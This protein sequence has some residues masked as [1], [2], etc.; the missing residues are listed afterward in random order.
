M[1]VDVLRVQGD[2]HII[3]NASTTTNGASGGGNITLDVGGNGVNTGTVVITGNLDVRG[4]TTQ[5]ESINATIKDNTLILNSGEPNNTTPGGVTNGTSGIM[6]SR[7]RA[8]ADT[9]SIG[10]FLEWNDNAQWAGTG[11]LSSVRGVWEFR[12]GPTGSG[13]KYSAIKV[14][15]IRIDEASASTAGS[16][17]GLGARLNI[18][19]SDN[20]TSVI[21]VSG[22]INYESRVTDKDDIPNK[23]YVDNTL[24][25][26]INTAQSLID[27]HSY[28]KIL[29]NYLDGVTSEVIAVLDG[30]PTQRL[31]ITTGTVVMRLT[32]AVAQFSEIQFV[33]N[34]IQPTGTNTDLKLATNGSGRIILEAPLVFNSLVTPTSP[35][36]GQTNL[37]AS[38][39][40]G[41]GTGMYFQTTDSLSV[42]TSDEFVSRKKALVFSIIFG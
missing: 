35:P 16:G 7:G 36:I 25:S 24:A 39:A 34:Q 13:A 23:A 20:P 11:V 5:I 10:A 4:T 1:T 41:G 12:E 27:G 28:L 37:Y 32:A 8:G 3:T 38:T 18:L 2:Y 40:G 17:Q 22:T 9:P 29:D 31:N 21:S 19:G 6:V 33:G 14:N 26:G 15:A 42:T 30:D